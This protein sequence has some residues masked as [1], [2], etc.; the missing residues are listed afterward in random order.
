MQA[1][2]ITFRE[3]VEA[4]S[5]CPRT[6]CSSLWRQQVSCPY[7]C[8]AVII[9]VL[10]A[11]LKKTNNMHMKPQGARTPVAPGPAHASLQH[12]VQTLRRLCQVTSGGPALSAR[13]AAG[14]P[15][16]FLCGE[17]SLA[18]QRTSFKLMCSTLPSAPIGSCAAPP[19]S[20]ARLQLPRSLSSVPI[21][22]LAWLSAPELL[23]LVIWGTACGIGMSIIL[24][25]AF[26]AAFYSVRG[27]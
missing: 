21:H 26:C 16:A 2:F 1:L 8:R 27:S 22:L 11:F 25:I 4:A 18:W 6:S 10:L 20:S 17:S 7:A 12:H 23:A 19:H 3:T 9:A 15:H 13:A 24:G 5:A 14:V